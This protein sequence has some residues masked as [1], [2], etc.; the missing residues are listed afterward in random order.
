VN[1]EGHE[2]HAE[3]LAM[4]LTVRLRSPQAECTENYLATDFTDFT[5]NIRHKKAQKGIRVIV[6]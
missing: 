6:N 3:N 5:E 2:E 4:E 1:H